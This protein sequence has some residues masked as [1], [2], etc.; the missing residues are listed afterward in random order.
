MS[1]AWTTAGPV[2][3]LGDD[4]TSPFGLADRVAASARVG[5][6][7]IDLLAA[8]L[9]PVVDRDGWGRV[10]DILDGHGIGHRQFELTTPWWSIGGPGQSPDA[11][12]SLLLEALERLGG[13]ELKVAAAATDLTPDAMLP[14]VVALARAV[15]DRGARLVIE[16]LPFGNLGTVEAGARYVAEA[17]DAADAPIGVVVDIWHLERGG[18]TV[19]AVED[20]L[21]PDQLACV[22]L[23]DGAAVGPPSGMTLG[24]EANDCRLLPGEGDFDLATWIRLFDRLGYD[25][26]WSIEMLSTTWR[27]LPLQ[28]AVERAAAATRSVLAAALGQSV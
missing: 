8:D 22:E 13:A 19:A 26:P 11:D 2:H 18:S 27:T 15:H 17:Q 7:G 25:R 14:S 21:R 1:A 20:S 6:T 10:A 28:D 5:F 9:A 12:R 16:P 4:L 24:D 23:C 3:P